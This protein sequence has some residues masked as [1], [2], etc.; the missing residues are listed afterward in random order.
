ME[1]RNISFNE[2]LHKYTDEHFNEY[3]SV[4]TCIGDYVP[5][6]D[7]DYWSKVTAAKQGKTQEEILKKWDKINKKSLDRG[8]GIHKELE[9]GILL[10]PD[11]EC[12]LE[13]KQQFKKLI[14]KAT[15]YI[16]FVDSPMKTEY[17][18]IY[19]VILDLLRKGWV[20]YPEYR[21]YT[22][23]HLIAGTIDCLLVKGGHIIETN[24]GSIIIKEAEF[25]ILDWKTNKDKLSFQS[26]YFKK[27]YKG[28]KTDEFVRKLEYMN[29][30][31]NYIENCKGSIYTLQL[32]L[33]ARILELWGN[34]CT[35]LALCHLRPSTEPMFYKIPYWKESCDLMLNDRISKIIIN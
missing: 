26:G 30:P 12:E 33:Y 5:V 28:N 13:R 35:G 23:D 29:S 24:W 20:C 2:Q 21:I 8:N 3:R 14:P 6:F 10:N 4:T 34:S 31:L 7:K 15:T 17:P 32:S 19:A 25:K 16:D 1:L 22:S 9:D 27:D 18:K 11:R